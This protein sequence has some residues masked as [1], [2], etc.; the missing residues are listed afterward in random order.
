MP[1]LFSHNWLIKSIVNRALKKAAT[2]YAQG[3]LLDIGCG[4]KQHESKFA[5]YIKQYI[6]VDH[7]STIHDKSKID[8]FATA[9]DTTIETATIDTVACLAVLEHLE[10]PEDA[11]KEMTRVLK[12]GGH[13]ILTGQFFWHLHEV[14][15]DFFRYTRFGLEYLFT[16]NG[17]EIIEIVPLSGFWVTFG[18]ELVYYLWR[19]RRGGRLNPLWWIIP[20]LGHIIQVLCY[21]LNLVDHSHEFAFLYLLIAKKK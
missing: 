9:Y 17:F 6:G 2:N 4:E 15:R 1:T 8:I 21:I 7:E 13:V 14:P 16:Q 5:P 11:I 20:M 10:R 12:P 18:Q 19:F 3:A